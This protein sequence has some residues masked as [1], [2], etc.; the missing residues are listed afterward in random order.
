MRNAGSKVAVALVAA[1]LLASPGFAAAAPNGAA[2]RSLERC[3]STVRREG[4]K[5]V[6]GLQKALGACFG[7]I[8]IEVLKKNAGVEAAVAACTRQ[9]DKIARTDGKSL[10][11]VFTAK[12]AAK[13]SPAPDNPHTPEDLSGLGFPEVAEPLRTVDLRDI[14]PRFGGDFPASANAWIACLRGAQECAVRDAIAAQFPRAIGW[15]NE[16][17]AAMPPSP[18]REA[19]LA[20]EAALDG[21]WDDGRPDGPCSIEVP[22]A[23]C[24]AALLLREPHEVLADL[25]AAL[26]AQDWDAVACQYHPSAFVIDDQGVLVGTNDI[27]ASAKS[28]ADLAN[29]IEPMIQDEA[30]FEDTVRV[31]FSLDAGWWRIED[32]TSTY[33]VRRGRIVQQTTHGL[34]E[35]V[36]PPPTD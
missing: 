4:A 22:A 3:Q 28:L 36:G 30:V 34:I 11:D 14:C 7:K 21:T 33:V 12:V 18:A 19:V 15:L 13:C 6:N 25:R 2:E 1:G 10:A 32:G 29:G 16:L 26:A 23:G 31:L 9:F 17:A 24:S 8:S 27:I 35:F 20:T 5:Y